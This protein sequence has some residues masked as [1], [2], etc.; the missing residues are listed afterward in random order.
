MSSNKLEKIEYGQP[1]NHYLRDSFR[2]PE[3]KQN[4]GLVRKF[5]LKHLERQEL[6]KGELPAMTGEKIQDLFNMLQIEARQF[7]SREPV[8]F[9][10]VDISHIHLLPVYLVIRAAI[11]DRYQLNRSWPEDSFNYALQLIVRVPPKNINEENVKD[12]LALIYE[13][14]TQ[15]QA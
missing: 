8:D 15:R 3:P 11:N 7:N 5:S 2:S 6:S 4:K 14:F 12:H 1:A 13:I 10:N 9:R